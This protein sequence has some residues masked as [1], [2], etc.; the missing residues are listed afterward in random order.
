MTTEEKII[1]EN[2]RKKAELLNSLSGHYL[3]WLHYKKLRHIVRYYPTPN[4]FLNY[5]LWALSRGYTP[6]GAGQDSDQAYVALI[7]YLQLRAQAT[8]QEKEYLN[9]IC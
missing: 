8:P 4:M 5:Q 3:S 7:A 1:I 2:A 9:N 6:F